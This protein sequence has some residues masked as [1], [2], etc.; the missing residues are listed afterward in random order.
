[1]GKIIIGILIWLC[2]VPFCMGALLLSFLK[3]EEDGVAQCMVTGY[4]IMFAVCQILVVPL[5]LTEVPFHVFSQT[6]AVIYL[7]LAAAGLARTRKWIWKMLTGSFR[8]LLHHSWT[9]Y[10]A[11][12]AVLVQAY[13][14]VQYMVTNLDDAY[15]VAV[16]T[17]AIQTDTMYRYS[18]YT[19]RAVTGFNLRYCLSPFSMFQAALSRWIGVHPS[20][21]DH[22]IL[23]P[24]LVIVAYLVYYCMGKLLFAGEDHIQQKKDSTEKLTGLF[25]LF[26]S[27]IHVTSYYCIRNQGSVLLVRIWQGKATLASVLIPFLFYHCYRMAK[28]PEEKGNLLILLITMFSCCL[29]SSMGIALPVVMLGIFALLFGLL[30]KNGRYFINMIIG[31][32]P[33]ALYGIL[34]IVLRN[35]L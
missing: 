31:C 12:A 8:D 27:M 4:F 15:Y 23:A 2:I 11:A 9:V 22:T 34:Y 6:L 7:I 21:L 28:R 35:V 33:C 29:V 10:A 16:A 3:R 19:G 32:I 25:I 18:P 30:Q 20:T 14:Y 24:A 13:Y 26:L 5:I 1:M 17:T